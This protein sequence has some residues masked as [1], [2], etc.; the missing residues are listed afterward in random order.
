MDATHIT[1]FGRLLDVMGQVFH[2]TL[3]RDHKAAYLLAL[4]DLPLEA[5]QYACRKVFRQETF[6]PVPAIVRAYA[7]EWLQHQREQAEAPQTTQELL[8]LREASVFPEELQALLRSVW[9][10]AAPRSEP[11]YEP[12]TDRKAYE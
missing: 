8:T 7:K 3:S 2:L 1:V 5:V 11:L 10:D 4:D 9:P 6:M 12:Q